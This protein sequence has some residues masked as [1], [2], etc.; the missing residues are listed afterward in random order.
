MKKAHRSKKTF[1]PFIWLSLAGFFLIGMV[2]SEVSARPFRLGV[3]PDK[4]ARFGCATCHVNPSGGGPRNAFGKDYQ[5]IAIPAGDKY[6]GELGVKDS[7]ED[8]ATNQQE[9][10]AG[11]H[12]GDPQSRPSK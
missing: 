10:E 8:G 9:F 6:S 12:P 7:D 2:F 1:A 4:G 11:T 5:Q 3:L